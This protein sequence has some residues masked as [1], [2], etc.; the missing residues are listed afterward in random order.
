MSIADDEEEKR[1]NMR[2]LSYYQFKFFPQKKYRLLILCRKTFRMKRTKNLLSR[3]TKKCPE[4]KYLSKLESVSVL[5]QNYVYVYV[6]MY[7]VCHHEEQKN[8][9]AVQ[10]ISRR[11]KCNTLSP[12]KM[13]NTYIQKNNTRTP[14][15]AKLLLKAEKLRQTD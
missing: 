14:T 2:K 7:I 10:R 3:A 13:K 1:I 11:C 12:R 4:R 6:C 8:E 15:Q 5:L 9:L